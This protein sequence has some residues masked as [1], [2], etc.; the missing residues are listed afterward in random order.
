VKGI[1]ERQVLT[2]VIERV[3]VAGST[4]SIGKPLVFL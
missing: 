4:E 2:L 3:H 1:K